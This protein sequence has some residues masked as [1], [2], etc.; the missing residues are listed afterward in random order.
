M[1]LSSTSV[2]LYLGLA[3]EKEKL[4]TNHWPNEGVGGHIELV[5]KL[6]TRAAELEELYDKELKNMDLTCVFDY[7]V[8]EEAGAWL[9]THWNAT[10]EEFQN[11]IRELA[12]EYEK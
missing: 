6:I 7:E 1:S 8:T 12:K 9:Y 10:K 2:Y 3:E 11:Y 4:T 5:N